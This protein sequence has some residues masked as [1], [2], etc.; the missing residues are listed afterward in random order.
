[1]RRPHLFKDL[2]L[3]MVVL[4]GTLCMTCAQFLYAKEAPS[5]RPNF[6]WIMLEDWCPDLSCYGT[7]GVYTPH[8]DQLAREGIRFTRAFTTAPVCS[9]SRSAM[10]TGHYQNY[11]GGNQHRTRGKQP[12]PYGIKPIPHI[13][14]EAGYYTALGCGLSGKTDCN[15]TTARKLFMGKHWR[16]RKPGQAFYAQATE[17]GTHRS[18]QRDPERPIDEKLVE[19]PPYYPDVPMM[20][21]DWAN[22]LE[23]AQ[24]SDRKVGKLLAELERDG[25]KENTVVILIGDHGRCMPRGKQFLYDGGLHIPMIIRWPGQVKAGQV[26]DDLVMSIDIC[27]TILD[28]A[29]VKAPHPLQGMNLFDP[30]IRL[31]Q[32]IFA[33]RD[34]M[35]DTHDAMRAIRT[36]DFKYIH[37][38][39]PERPYMQFNAYKEKQYAPVAL[40][41]VMSMRGELNEVQ[42]RFMASEK[43]V[44]ELYD[45]KNDPFETKNLAGD[46]PYAAVKKDLRQQLDA[47]RKQV[48]DKGVTKA[49]RTGGW[50]ATYPTKTLEQWEEIL[51]KW[52]PW[53]FRRPDQK[54]VT[55]PRAVINKTALVPD[56]SAKAKIKRKTK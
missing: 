53:V 36:R 56:K 48:K 24:L 51:E 13:L 37:N 47:W 6:L 28:M 16:D 52:E 35:D 46:S 25:L 34:K 42:A 45:L 43:P 26:C 3:G 29:G 1:M 10:M 40:L 44:E 39:M 30:A 32:A 54:R 38:L 14:E 55:H 21:R 12:L 8:I 41:N 11:N 31:R 2:G 19:L 20:R 7:K 9:A 17:P 4:I 22:G 18:W 33:A 23:Q 49:F 15:F 50:P 5:E 27:Q